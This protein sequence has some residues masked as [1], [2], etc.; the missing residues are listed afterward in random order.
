MCNVCF[1]MSPKKRKS[2]GDVARTLEAS[3]FEWLADDLVMMSSSPSDSHIYH[4][5]PIRVEDTWAY[6]NVRLSIQDK[7]EADEVTLEVDIQNVS[8]PRPGSKMKDN[9]IHLRD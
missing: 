2:F 9:L 6:K 8:E 1:D 4:G 3:D 7:V 5:T